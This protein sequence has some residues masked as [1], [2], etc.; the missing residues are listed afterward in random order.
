M[1]SKKK[2]LKGGHSNNDTKKFTKKKSH[3]LSHSKHKKISDIDFINPFYYK[4]HTIHKNMS[5]DS[6]N[7]NT[8]NK[9][10]EE[11]P[12]TP[13]TYD[14]IYSILKDNKKNIKE[15]VQPSVKDL[16]SELLSR[17]CDFN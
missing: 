8:L 4:G 13:I 6:N 16:D 1:Q 3:S 15:D 12:D 2:I 7:L 9:Y 11:N 17:I 14:K 5:Y 10:I